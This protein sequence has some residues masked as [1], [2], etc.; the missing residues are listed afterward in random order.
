M[1][2]VA[3]AEAP[4][5]FNAFPRREGEGICSLYWREKGDTGGRSSQA[6]RPANWIVMGGEGQM[7]STRK[8]FCVV[9]VCVI[10]EPDHSVLRCRHRRRRRP[11]VV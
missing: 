5:E 1:I 11:R 3:A 9:V 4:D 10:R 8:P 7:D 6:Y 2:K